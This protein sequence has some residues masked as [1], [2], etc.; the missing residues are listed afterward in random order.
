[1]RLGSIVLAVR[2]LDASRRWYEAQLG[3]RVREVDESAGLILLD[4][5]S[6]VPVC[7]LRSPG[8]D[9]SAGAEHCAA[10]PVFLTDDARAKRDAF[11]AA[12]VACGPMTEDAICRRFSIRDLDG[13]RLDIVELIRAIA[14]DL[15]EAGTQ[16][17]SDMTVAFSAD[18]PGTLARA[19]EAL[20]RA[21]LDTGGYAEI[22]GYFHLLVPDPE[23]ARLAFEHAGFRVEGN[24]RVVV[25]GAG[26][27]PGATAALFRQVADAGIN[28]SFTYATAD[29]R[30]VIGTSEVERLV[31][32]L[33]SAEGD[34]AQET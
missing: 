26:D 15:P 31:D 34:P 12:G 7:L 24:Q 1:M 21:G 2:D 25:V 27:R 29:G 18:Q 14:R 23:A 3:L 11:S 4:A 33:G 16:V 32:A 10:F 20:T 8:R 30:L 9:A 13:N 19:L 6:A 28:V 17:A 5:G 22:E